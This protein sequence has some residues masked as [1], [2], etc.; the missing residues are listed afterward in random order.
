MATKKSVVKKVQDVSKISNIRWDKYY[1]KKQQELADKIAKGLAKSK[2][3]CD[4]KIPMLVAKMLISR[5]K[6]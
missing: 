5:K 1:A 3:E 4:A 2:V 6:K